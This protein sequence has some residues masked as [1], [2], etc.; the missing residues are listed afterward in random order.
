VMRRH[1]DQL[2]RRL[3]ARR[4]VERRLQADRTIAIEPQTLPNRRA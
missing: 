1:Y 4:N 2:N 3:I